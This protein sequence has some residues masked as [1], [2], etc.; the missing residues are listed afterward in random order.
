MGIPKGEKVDALSAQLRRKPKEEKQETNKQPKKHPHR[1]YPA[2][3]FQLLTSGCTRSSWSI[4][5]GAWANPNPNETDAQPPPKP[6]PK[7]NHRGAEPKPKP[8]PFLLLGLRGREALE[9]DQNPSALRSNTPQKPPNKWPVVRKK[10]SCVLLLL[11]CPGIRIFLDLRKPR[12]NGSG[13]GGNQPLK[14]KQLQGGKPSLF[15]S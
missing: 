13:F 10:G 9:N 15:T 11:P 4:C 6:K 5:V 12:E 7:P 2:S 3:C 14:G 1:C 8:K